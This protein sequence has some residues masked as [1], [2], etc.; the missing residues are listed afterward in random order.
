MELIRE[1]AH[2][3][4]FSLAFGSQLFYFLVDSKMTGAGFIRLLN[5][6][7]LGCLVVSMV[8]FFL[9]GISFN[10]IFI[11]Y[12]FLIFLHVLMFAFHKDHRT[13]FSWGLYGAQL[14]SYLALAHLF[15]SGPVTNLLYFLGSSLF[16]GVTNYA[17]ILGHYYLVVPKLSER[18]LLVAMKIFWAVLTFKVLLTTYGFVTGHEFFLEGSLQGSGYLFNWIIL[19]MRVL[20]GYV[21]LGVLSIFGYKLARMRSI[22]SATGIYYVM[23]FFVFVGEL[24][25]AYL[26]FNYGLLI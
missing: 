21:A 20:W 7:N 17:M 2:F 19:S 9:D 26:F 11:I 6:V 4:L 24:T 15:F 12:V 1:V 5:G 16:L 8:I 23:D 10:N 3:F 25:S 18:P 14:L 22:Q 13:S